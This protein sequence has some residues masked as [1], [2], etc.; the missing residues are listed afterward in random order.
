MNPV[1]QFDALVTTYLLSLLTTYLNSP[2]DES[3]AT[4]KKA[5]AWYTNEYTTMRNQLTADYADLVAHS[6]PLAIEDYLVWD[7]GSATLDGLIRLVEQAGKV[8]HS[9]AEERLQKRG[10]RQATGWV[11]QEDFELYQRVMLAF[12]I[13]ATDEN[14]QVVVAEWNDSRS[15]KAGSR[16]WPL[17]D[18][19]I[20]GIK[21]AVA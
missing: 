9:A 10:I 21:A 20:A 5:Y 2:T 17:T 4:Y 11:N 18:R 6:D 15:I 14:G 7:I 1:Q 13:T 19:E 3:G 8:A 16:V 12:P